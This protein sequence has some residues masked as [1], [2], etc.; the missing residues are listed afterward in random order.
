MIKYLRWL[1]TD[2]RYVVI[3]GQHCGC[4]G[5]WQ[6]RKVMIPTYK[7]D[8]FWDRWGLCDECINKDS[9]NNMLSKVTDDNKHKLQE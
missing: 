3:D 9:L 5:K 4:C 6:E 8:D 2:G 1:F 7:F